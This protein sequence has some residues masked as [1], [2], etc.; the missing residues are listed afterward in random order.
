MSIRYLDFTP[1]NQGSKVQEAEANLKQALLESLHDLLQLRGRR[2]DGIRLSES[3]HSVGS[4]VSEIWTSQ[5]MWQH[6]NS[7]RANWTVG[8]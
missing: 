7:T 3:L 2:V 5:A 4:G 8:S 6:V 1:N